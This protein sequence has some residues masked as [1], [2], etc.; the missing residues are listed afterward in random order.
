M[1][2]Y[3]ETFG[4]SNN[5][6]E[7]EMMAGIL[8]RS[9]FHVVSSI[10][11]ADIVIVNTCVVKKPTEDK[12]LAFLRSIAVKY[13]GKKLIAAGCMPEVCYEKIRNAAPSASIVST[14][15][16]SEIGKAVRKVMDGSRVE[17]LGVARRE[18]LCIPR[19]R[20]NECV[21]IVPISSGCLSNCAY[22][23]VKNV[24]A[25]LFSYSQEKIIQEISSSRKAGCREFWL[26]GQDCSCYGFDAGSNLPLLLKNI[27]S[28]VGGKYWLRIGMLNPLHMKKIYPGLVEAYNDSHI[29]KFLHMPVQSGSDAVLGSM[30]RGYRVSDFRRI[31]SEFEK[32]IPG[33]QLWTDVIVG[34]PGESDD[35]FS[36]TCS[37]LQ[38]VKPD[39]V[40]VSKYGPR[41]G[42]KA[43]SMHQLDASVVGDR[44]RLVSKLVDE[45]AIEKNKRW[46]G[47]SGPVLVDEY[48]YA[49]K[50]WIGRNFAYKPVAIAGGNKLKFGEIVDV[51][52][53]GAGRVLTG[54]LTT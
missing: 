6:A 12:I 10:E 50:S 4:C 11:P 42:T 14:H 28:S 15:H 25:G 23:I 46:L 32:I 40:N 26:T 20:K 33:I 35:D 21:S 19:V 1:D 9:G 18:K 43:E 39:F 37:L 16:V 3:I 36:A 47:W 41:T 27:I 34:F 49:K 45:I 30:E 8:S 7:S 53:T 51:E 24:K 29:F 38:D 22:C 17:L 13:P 54:T 2:V 44:S 48:N 5:Q 52:V 31:V